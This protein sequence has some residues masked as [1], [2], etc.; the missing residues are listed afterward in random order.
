M[1]RPTIA[2][3]ASYPMKPNIQAVLYNL[4]RLLRDEF[5]FDLIMGPEGPPE[6]LQGLYETFPFR[7]HLKL[8]GLG[9]AFTAT[10]KYLNSYQPDAI[11]NAGQPFPLG[12]AIVSLGNW[13]DVPT[14]LRVT[15]DY[16]AESEIGS[17]WERRKRKLLHGILFNAVYQNA[18][19][20]IP[21]GQNLADKLLRNGFEEE[22]VYPLPQPFD[23][24]PFSALSL[25]E[26]RQL[27]EELGLELGRKTVLFVGRLSWG[28][29]ADRVL[30][31]AKG[32]HQKSREFQFCLVGDGKYVSD[33]QRQFAAEEV[34]C[35][36][37]VPRERV[38]EYFKVADLLI[39]P[40]RRDA[41]PNVILEALAARVPVIASPVGE[42]SNLISHTSHEIEDYVRYILEKNWKYNDLPKCLNWITQK[43][44]YTKLL[45]RVVGK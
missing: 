21:V 3:L 17:M 8:N 19:V 18:D 1:E 2:L 4:G 13:Y 31:I 10:R 36:G 29:G 5:T 11:I 42:M 24:E 32:V 26:R 35:A 44:N 23:P 15:G 20:A 25:A 28:K 7:P 12:L 38:P 22:Q 27:K 6:Q 39:H 9:F 16:F 37:Y 45:K 34:F 33:F 30:E 41:L 14:I 40:S 43:K